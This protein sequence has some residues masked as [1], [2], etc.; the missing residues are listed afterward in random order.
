[1][2][3]CKGR[4][5]S[6]KLHLTSIKGNI[7]H[8]E[9]ASGGAALAK[10]LL[11]LHNQ[12]IPAQISLKT[13]NPR[14]NKLS[15]D[16]AVIDRESALWEAGETPRLAMLNNFGAAGSNGALLLQ[17]PPP[18]EHDVKHPHEA[19][20]RTYHL[21]I[22]AKSTDALS[23]LRED[24][25]RFLRAE[26]LRPVDLGDLCYTFTA[27][28]QIYD[29]RISVTAGSTMEMADMLA[30][31][32]LT[33]IRDVPETQ[34]R[35]A[36]IFSGQGVQYV[37]MGADLMDIYPN[38][39]ETVNHCEHLLGE[40]GLP[41]CLQVMTPKDDIQ[42]RMKE[43]A[44]QQAFQSAVFVLQVA[45]ARLLMS[46][47][48][49]PTVL[50]GHSL[51]EYAAL[52]IAGVLDLKDAMRLVAKRAELFMRHCNIY[53]TSML[54]VNTSQS[55]MQEILGEHQNISGL[56][57]AC[58]NSPLD[59]VVGGSINQLETLKDLIKNEHNIKSK[60]LEVPLAYHT[61]AV[62]PVMNEL[63]EIAKS[64]A[65]NPPQLPVVSNVFGRIVHPGENAFDSGYFSRHCR[66]TVAFNEGL[67]DVLAAQVSG[68]QLRWLEIGPSPML[69]P[70]VK[71]QISNASTSLLPCLK[72]G[73]S[74]SRTL[75]N[76]VEELFLN[77]N[78]IDW[79][80]VHHTSSRPQIIE[81]PT[82]PFQMQQFV[83]PCHREFPGKEA[84]HSQEPE[85]PPYRFLSSKVQTPSDSNGEVAIYETP[86]NDLEEFIA[87]HM[88]ADHALCPASVYHEI[89]LS[90]ARDSQEDQDC[91]WSISDVSYQKPLVYVEGS[92][93][94]VRATIAPDTKST[95][96]LNFSI[97]SQDNEM[98]SEPPTVHCEGKIKANDSNAVATKQALAMPSLKH[99]S[100]MFAR[101]SAMA[102]QQTFFTKAMYEMVFP[103]VVSYSTLY[104]SVQC[105]RIDAD[106]SE[107]L[108]QCKL[109]EESMSDLSSSRSVLMDTVLHVAG[110]VANI[111][112]NN[113]DAYICKEAKSAKVLQD[114]SD[115]DGTFEVYC[116]TYDV[117]NEPSTVSD[118]F[119][120]SSKGTLAVFK[121]MVFSKA[122]LAHIAKAF[123][124][125][126]GKTAT[127]GKK[128]LAPSPSAHAD[129]Q[130]VNH[131]LS[132]EKDQTE[133][134]SSSRTTN[135]R[136]LLRKVS[137]VKEN[138]IQ[139]HTSLEALGIDSLL[140]IELGKLLSAE[141]GSPFAP[142]ALS[143]CKTVAD[144]EHLVTQKAPSTTHATPSSAESTQG[145]SSSPTDMTKP[146]DDFSVA[147]IISKTCGVDPS[148]LAPNSSLEA[149]G[150]D[151][152]MLLEL[153][154]QLAAVPEATPFS[155]SELS[156]CRTVDDVQRLVGLPCKL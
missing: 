86:I 8:C 149:L 124:V 139:E 95:R 49:Q 90:A 138:S 38:F 96:C 11:M 28:R 56:E 135:V 147:Q 46:W 63:T 3:L 57:I 116:T 81:V 65:I 141:L 16:G 100:A 125:L 126:S 39:A 45:L 85:T 97:A 6:N 112:A 154:S 76:V 118:A 32:N 71:P 30:E 109:P 152:L 79:R 10:L 24:L 44:I 35:S 66:E 84:E 103:R 128:Q 37:G 146:E 151:S 25:V 14:I 133:M 48:V 80:Q 106:L 83:V 87:G 104:R 130:A 113:G 12:S 40:L 88:V 120:M 121:G 18:Y 143:E 70:M 123:Q 20:G 5:P 107:A 42:A 54:A 41:G 72:R 78:G 129:L 15:I 75:S 89:A 93:V 68:T 52:T 122:K 51:G 4:A 148:T 19:T 101:E 94:T 61:K 21:G 111:R 153:E 2:A 132:T 47:N 136:A 27:R 110:F 74:A 99:K 108:A 127:P 22:S 142:S 155:S 31:S 77:A 34:P 36:F 59:C 102:T 105:I 92:S 137:G 64:C 73:T 50:Q 98:P 150:I 117:P 23:A 33:N 134:N 119:A 58:N 131:S 26:N 29:N 82:M 140:V 144:L 145:T 7:G 13:L 9:A 43:P 1:M 115:F 114:L 67:Q 60:T 91:V 53:T 69:I 55:S 156:A 62:N 17:Q